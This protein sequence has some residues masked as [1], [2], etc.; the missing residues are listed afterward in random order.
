MRN[1]SEV[2][3]GTVTNRTNSILTP[4][5][6]G[7][8]GGLVCPLIV[9]NSYVHTY[10]CDPATDFAVLGTISLLLTILNIVCIFIMGII[11]LKVSSA[12]SAAA[13]ASSWG[14]HDYHFDSGA[15]PDDVQ[16]RCFL[17]TGLKAFFVSLPQQNPCS[18]PSVG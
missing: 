7:G 15:V 13:S 10:F 14:N 5:L 8:G 1:I 2:I 4:K 16:R 11:V 6:G 9:D 17:A 18:S 12:A 3:N